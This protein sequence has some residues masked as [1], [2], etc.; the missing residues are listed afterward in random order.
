MARYL[1]NIYYFTSYNLD[2]T[3]L[4]QYNLNNKIL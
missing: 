2:K 1:S 4:S 3:A